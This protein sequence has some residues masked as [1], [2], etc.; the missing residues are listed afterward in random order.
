M[1]FNS[2]IRALQYA[3]EET[4]VIYSFPEK[5]NEIVLKKPMVLIKDPVRG[6][7]VKKAI[8]E[9]KATLQGP[10]LLR[11]GGLGVVVRC[12]IFNG[13]QFL[14]L[15]IGVYDLAILLKEALDGMVG[16][17]YALSLKDP[18]QGFFWGVSIKP[19]PDSMH[20]PVYVMDKKWEV[21]LNRAEAAPYILVMRLALWLL[22]LLFFIFLAYRFWIQQKRELY[23]SELEQHR[24]A[25][26]NEAKETLDLT[27]MAALMGGWSLNVKRKRVSISNEVC[28]LLGMKDTA[29][30]MDIEEFCSWFQQHENL[31]S[32]LEE[33][34][35][36]GSSIDMELRLKEG[37]EGEQWLHLVGVLKNGASQIQGVLRDI[38]RAKIAE[39][40]R[41]K[42][43]E[44]YRITLNSIGDAVIATDTEGEVTHMN[45]VAEALTG[46]SSKEAFGR[47]L[48]DVFHIV[49]ET[50]RLPVSDPVTRV[51][52]TGELVTL[53]NHTV[54][55]SKDGKEYL[56]GDSGAPI[57]NS[58]RKIIGVVL[59]FRDMTA[60]Y[61]TQEELLK[62]QKLQS[63]GNLAGGIV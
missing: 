48:Q 53:E 5:R 60:E 3:N 54:L 32:R 50:T 46:W 10:Y 14:G 40:E 1:E 22:G 62:V 59:V 42:S 26:L 52:S 41:K 51:L 20:I 63:V 25:Q 37:L 49:N 28:L 29:R 4:Q 7:Y 47:R 12:P 45:P 8:E 9:R 21:F 35:G 17:Q 16:E 33:C 23:L 27:S 31:Y 2:P 24:L 13:E 38:S 58:E 55:I 44:N 15:A 18:L 56:I 39:E 61:K 34:I 57:F 30:S 19:L 43:E 36:E 6:P 11:Q